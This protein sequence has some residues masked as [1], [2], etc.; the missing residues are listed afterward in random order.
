MPTLPGGDVSAARRKGTQ[1]HVDFRV[2][3]MAPAPQGSKRHV[4]NGVM[5]ESSQRV[6]PWR[7]AVR[8]AALAELGDAPPMAG[9]VQVTVFYGLP[10]PKGHYGTGRNAETL[11]PSAPRFPAVKPDLDKL[12]RGLFDALTGLVWQ[13]DAQVVA[14]TAHKVYGDPGARVIVRQMLGAGL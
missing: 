10:R 5:V 6:K 7:E 12:D 2:R 14:V 1:R 3:G 4:G 8:W 13:D 11:R 9:P